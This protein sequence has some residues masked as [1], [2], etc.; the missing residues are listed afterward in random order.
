MVSTSIDKYILEII[1][2]AKASRDVCE[3]LLIYNFSTE[4]PKKLA[5]TIMRICD[6]LIRVVILIR[7]SN[8][9]NIK[10]ELFNVIDKIIQKVGEY[11]KYVDAAK[12]ERH[13]WSIVPAFNKLIRRVMGDI[14][15]LQIMLFPQWKY[16]YQIY[17]M[18]IREDFYTTLKE[19]FD[20]FPGENIE[21]DVLKDMK[22][23]FYLISFPT[24][25]RK[26]ILLH[27]LI[28]H[29]VGHLFAAKYITQEKKNLFSEKVSEKTEEI[30][31][32]KAQI[33]NM[34]EGGFEEYIVRQKIMQ[35]SIYCWTRGLEELLS[36]IVNAILFGPAALFAYYE[37][38]AQVGFR[39]DAPS[40]EN[41]CYPPWNM[42]LRV[43]LDILEKYGKEYFPL[44]T[45]VLFRDNVKTDMVNQI[46]NDIKIRIDEKDDS[47]SIGNDK[48][49]KMI[50]EQIDEE[51]KVATDYFLGEYSLKEHL[52]TSDELY[53][54]M[55]KLI[56][57]L[58]NDIPPNEVEGS[59]DD[60]K[61]ATMI[62]IINAAWFYKMSW[63]EIEK[64]IDAI[65]DRYNK[66]DT[67]NNLTLKAIEYA[68]I[69]SDYLVHIKKG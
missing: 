61:P 30:I 19:L 37:M 22:G 14:P 49:L 27:S 16:N 5:K 33:S 6:F 58:E 32:E 45:E 34:P 47:E 20:F 57:R 40:L 17:L 56:D 4:A 31:K 68:D 53:Q 50:Y 13:P 51:L 64:G 65:N 62:E 46:F 55:N 63:P 29:E 43:V 54:N 69:E 1:S 52:V 38:Y 18:D 28:G 36:D 35:Y 26:N 42:R 25:E 67:M 21:S 15:D 39:S 10:L 11:I 2:R 44:K 59:I 3:K 8:D 24:L 66:R 60:R 7:Q 48:T 9:E 12:F 41:K 23:S